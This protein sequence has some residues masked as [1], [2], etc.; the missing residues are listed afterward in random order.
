MSKGNDNLLFLYADWVRYIFDQVPKKYQNAI[1]SAIMFYQIDGTEPPT[2]MD[3]NARMLFDTLRQIMD[4][5][6]FRKIKKRWEKR[7]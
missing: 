6:D 7:N 1:L 4:N 2:D 3:K 5:S